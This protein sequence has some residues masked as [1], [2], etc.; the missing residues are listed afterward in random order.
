MTR[1]ASCCLFGL[2][3][4]LLS[5]SLLWGQAGPKK[6]ALL[7]G[8]E[9]YQHEKLREP[10]LQYPVEDVTELATLLRKQGYEVIL[11]TDEAQSAV[12]Q[13]APPAA[14]TTAEVRLDKVM[15]TEAA[16][17]PVQKHSRRP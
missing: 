1:V 17:T 11:L 12:P 3:V 15:G 2:A 5:G 9:A 4:L 6:Y 13:A 16:T 10:A 14:A 8:V 7:V